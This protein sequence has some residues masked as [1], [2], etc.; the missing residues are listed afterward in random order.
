MN[1]TIRATSIAIL[2]AIAGLL[3]PSVASAHSG[4][5]D[6]FGCHA[7]SQ[8]YH[9]HT[10]PPA[11]TGSVAERL[12]APVSASSPSPV[13]PTAVSG[14]SSSTSGTGLWVAQSD[15]AVRVVGGATAFGDV[16]GARLNAPIVGMARTADAGGYWLLG[17]DGG[18]FSYGNAVFRGSTGNIKLNQPVVSIASDSKGR[19]YWFAAA[20]GGVFAFGS[21]YRGSAANLR[22]AQ[23]VVGMASTK[24]GDGYWLVA[25]DGGI[26]SYGDAVFSGSTGAIRLNQPIVGMAADPDGVGYWL[27]AADGGVFSFDA[28]FHG[29]GVGN[30]AVGDSVTAM[31][32]HPGGGYWLITAKGQVL[33]YGAAAV[34]GPR[35]VIGVAAKLEALR[36]AAPDTSPYNRDSWPHWIDADGDC[37]DTRDEVLIIESTIAVTLSANGCDVVAGRWVDIYTNQVF[38]DPSLLDI[39]HMVPLANAHRSGGASFDTARKS[40]FANYLAID[41]ALIAVSASANRSKGD[42]SPDQWLPPNGASHCRYATAWVDVKS[43]WTLTVTVAEKAR[44]AQLLAAC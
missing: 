28:R 15:G 21:T 10:T 18:V 27:V 41:D 7:G 19:G 23:P 9:C 34:S 24:S 30:V 36:T 16:G 1:T 3:V 2:L 42:N 35:P 26:F 39:D 33:P 32:A 25:R 4:E 29:S 43:Q 44:L 14:A 20:D 22:L 38:T 5:L 12:A 17:R 11:P 37:Q 31:V 8:P 6:K 13:G 40:A